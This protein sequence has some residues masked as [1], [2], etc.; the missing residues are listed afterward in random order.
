LRENLFQWVGP[1]GT[2]ATWFYTKAGSGIT[3]SSI[4]DARNLNSVGT[5]S[6]WFS[7]QYL[8]DLGFTNLISDSDPNVMTEKL[9]HGEIDA[10]VCTGV[11]FPT[12]LKGLG[13]QYSEVLP[14]YS[15]M[16]S[17]Y[18]IAFSKNTP[19]SR[20]DQWQTT[21]DSMKLDGTYEV[22]FKKWMQ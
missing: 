6:S 10:F 3:I 16:S 13:Y 14:A 5:V 15:L 4:E 1:I 17:D 21:L 20:I 19:V 18:Y 2:N 12:I 9:L 7:D 22:L 11:T 8:R